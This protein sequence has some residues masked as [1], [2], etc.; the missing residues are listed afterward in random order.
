MH[1]VIL[2]NLYPLYPNDDSKN[3]S[4][5]WNASQ[6]RPQPCRMLRT[7]QGQLDYINSIL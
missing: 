5:E 4:C 1:L 7:R 3:Q 2:N 6:N